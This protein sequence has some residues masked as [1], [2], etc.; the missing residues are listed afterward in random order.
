LINQDVITYVDKV[1]RKA[2]IPA[3]YKSKLENELFRNILLATDNPRLDTVMNLLS[4]PDKLAEEI[5]K[6][7]ENHPV[8]VEADEKRLATSSAHCPPP[9]PHYPHPRYGGEYM[10]EH[11]NVNLKLLYIP[12]LQI[13]SG[14]ERFTMPLTEGY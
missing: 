13:S 7:Y 8:T 4:S 14:T 10:R 9:P 3:E 11:S 1:I 2:D 12:L 6:K 5:T